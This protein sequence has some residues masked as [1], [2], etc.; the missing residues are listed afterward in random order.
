MARGRAAGYDDQR[1][2]ILDQAAQLFARHGYSATSMNLVAEACGLSKATLYHYFRDKYSMLVSIADGHVSH[3][4]SLVQEPP[5]VGAT[6]RQRL[7]QLIHRIVATYADAEHAHRVLTEDVRFLEPQDQA[8][9]L[10]K[11]RQVVAVFAQAVAAVRPELDRA[12]L[13]KPL[14]ML[15]FGMIN[16]MFTWMKS[17]GALTHEDMAPIVADLFLG[18]LPAVAS[19]RGEASRNGG[20]PTSRQTGVALR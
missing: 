18:G 5:P 15:L 17:D 8:R 2:A 6:P 1:Q 12:G 13:A 7:E 4:Q 16:W 3:L 19:E 20:K 11:E 14:T 10:D 9:V